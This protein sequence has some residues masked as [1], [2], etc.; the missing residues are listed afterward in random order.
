[1][2]KLILTGVWV[3]AVTLVA[4]Y[5]AVSWQASHLAPRAETGKEESFRGLEYIKPKQLSVPI[6]AD[7]EIQGYVVAQFVFTLKAQ[8][9]EQLKIEPQAFLHDEAFKAIYASES[10]D[11]RRLKKQDLSSLSKKI[12]ENVNK[13]F[14]AELVEEALI[15]ELAYVPKSEVRDGLRRW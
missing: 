12:A 3:C 10:I 7:G 5:A 11:F 9:L 6:I 15:Q 14:G 1:M 8:V 4:S 2:I 13:R